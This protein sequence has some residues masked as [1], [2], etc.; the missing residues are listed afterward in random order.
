MK[1][2]VRS[3]HFNDL[4]RSLYAF[5][6]AV[7]YRNRALRELIRS[8]RVSIAEWDRQK[9][10]QNE[11]HS[12]TLLE[13][14]FSTLFLNRTN[15]S[16]IIRG[17][18]IGG[19]SQSGDWNIKSRFNKDR[20]IERIRQLRDFSSQ[21]SISNKDVLAIN[22]ISFGTN[23]PSLVYLDPPYYQKAS[24]LYMN[25]LRHEDHATLANKIEN[26]SNSRVVVTYDTAKPIIELYS[27]YKRRFFDLAHTAAKY[28]VGREVMFFSDNLRI[29]R[30]IP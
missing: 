6:Y 4:D 25:H 5:W 18:M 30:Y 22:D 1:G 8:T 12:S 13:L 17:G 11:K 2:V 29:P 20:I 10:I 15:R 9:L 26:T 19:R 7:K 24:R 21:I 28:K 16:G 27:G 23:S 14:G 3:V